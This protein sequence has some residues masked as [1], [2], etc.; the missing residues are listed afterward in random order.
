MNISFICNKKEYNFD[1]P[2]ETTLNYI[3][4]LI[5]KIFK[6]EPVDILYKGNKIIIKDDD[7]TTLLKD[8]VTE[9]DSTIRLKIILGSNEI[10]ETSKE[11]ILIKKDNLDNKLFESLF[12]KKTKIVNS[13][14]NEFNLKILE[15]NNFLYKQKDGI[16]NDN[17]T[18]FEKK[19]YEF[20]DNLIIYIRKLISIL[21]KNT[22]YA[23]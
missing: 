3:K 7:K 8:I 13:A 4:K 5:S 18:T 19:I 15:I 14:L 23:Y 22:L 11:V 9:V 12:T 6:C 21:E 20:I 16:K 17:L 2:L 10:N 1:L